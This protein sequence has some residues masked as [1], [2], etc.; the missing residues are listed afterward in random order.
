MVLRGLI[1]GRAHLAYIVRFSRTQNSCGVYS[2]PS[3][4]NSKKASKNEASKTILSY[5]NG[6][7]SWGH[8]IFFLRGLIFGLPK[9]TLKTH[10][11]RQEKHQKSLGPFNKK[12][13]YVCVQQ[14]NL[15]KQHRWPGGK[16]LSS[17]FSHRTSSTREFWLPTN[18]CWNKWSQVEKKQAGRLE[19]WTTGCL[20][21]R[22]PENVMVDE[23]IPTNNWVVF[24]PP[25]KK[26]YTEP[27]GPF[28]SF[29]KWT[30]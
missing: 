29:L 2:H 25:K 17:A 27:G 1:T 20:Y 19:P 5:W 15:A 24:H 4:T 12:N 13:T 6:P 28:F 9:K 30:C 11:T 22:D 21:N 26:L 8:L 23:V 10:T 14:K 3:K 16:H 7:F 18:L